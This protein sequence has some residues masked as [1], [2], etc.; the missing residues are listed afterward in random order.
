MNKKGKI[1]VIIALT[2]LLLPASLILF[3]SKCSDQHCKP[4][5]VVP[6]SE[7][8]DTPH[9][10]PNFRFVNQEGKT[11]TQDSLKGY[12]HVADFIFTTCPGICKDL[13]QNFQKLQDKTKDFAELKI[14]SFSV[15]PV[16]DSVPVLAAYAQ[17]YKADKHKWYFLTGQEDS[18]FNVIIQ[19]Y[20]QSAYKS[21]LGK[22]KVTHSPVSVLVDKDLRIRGFYNLIDPDKGESEFKRLIEEIDVLRCEYRNKPKNK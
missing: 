10:I 1:R 4:L 12:Y 11:I 2:I 22:E 15:D 18:I 17:K 5:M 7:N 16:N 6:S 8:A 21:P 3:L 13:S 19:G 20:K 14:I 9:T